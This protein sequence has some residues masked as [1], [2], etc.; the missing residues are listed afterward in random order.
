MFPKTI[1]F[2][3]YQITYTSKEEFKI[4]TNEI[5]TEEIYKTK[6]NTTSPTILDIGSHIGLSIIY[7]KDIYPEAEIIGFE[8]NPNIFPILEEN[9]YSNALQKVKLHNVA[10]AEKKSNRDLYIDT[11]GEGAFSTSSFRKN[12]WNGKQNTRAITVKCEKLSSYITKEIDLLKIDAEGAETEIIRELYNS[13]KLSMI[14]NIIVEYHPTKHSNIK[15]IL[16]YLKSFKHIKQ[17]DL[18]EN[19][20]LI[21]GEK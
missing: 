4:L 7:F 16:N 11:S 9:I 19:L 8:P 12:A 2:K 3:K 10:L 17:K 14:K 15:N 21:L 20:I 1:K 6:L 13:G 5:F 18:G